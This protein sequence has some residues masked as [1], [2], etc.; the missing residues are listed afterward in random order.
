MTCQNSSWACHRD[1]S[2]KKI[3]FFIH[4]KSDLRLV[5]SRFLKSGSSTSVCTDHIFEPQLKGS[6]LQKGMTKFGEAK[7]SASPSKL[8]RFFQKRIVFAGKFVC[9]LFN[10]AA[11]HVD[12]VSKI[13]LNWMKLQVT[14]ELQS[15]FLLFKDFWNAS[16]M[17]KRE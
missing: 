14:R 11:E 2:T 17:S 16:A 5:K 1:I 4:K 13:C 7:P 8:T 3:N 15:N 6:Q 9:H 12:H 10:Q